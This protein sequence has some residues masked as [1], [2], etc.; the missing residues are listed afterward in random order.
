MTNTTTTE[1]YPCPTCATYLAIQQAEQAIFL[2]KL[3]IAFAEGRIR[4]GSVRHDKD[5][6]ATRTT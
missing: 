5:C 6:P 2:K 1:Q 3:E 4:A